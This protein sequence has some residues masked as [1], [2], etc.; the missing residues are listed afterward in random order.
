MKKAPRA[1]RS[2]QADA[3]DQAPVSSEHLT[4]LPGSWTCYRQ[5]R[6]PS[7]AAEE[8]GQRSLGRQ[9]RT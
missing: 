1:L 4:G 9:D 6:R 2:A 5:C 8:E 3:G 7:S